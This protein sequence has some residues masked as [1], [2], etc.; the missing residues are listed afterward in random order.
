ME[1]TGRRWLVVSQ[2]L[3]EFPR[4][5]LSYP[6]YL[7]GR[8]RLTK[9]PDLYRLVG[10]RFNKQGHLL[11]RLVLGNH[12]MNSFLHPPIRISKVYIEA[13]AGI[14]SHTQR[15]LMG[16]IMDLVQMVSSSP[17]YLKYVSLGSF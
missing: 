13:L 6:P 8:E 12:K 3:W 16:L 17:Y 5:N 1:A 14:Q 9:K 10:C 2:S 4:Y 15:S 7:E 11:M